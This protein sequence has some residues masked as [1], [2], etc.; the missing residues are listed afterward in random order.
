MQLILWQIISWIFKTIVIK[1]VVLTAL[2][3]VVS[4]LVPYAVSH[5]TSFTNVSSLN[6]AFSGIPDGLWWVLD[7][8]RLDYGLPLVISAFISR[9][10]IRRL[11]VI[12]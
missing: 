7:F 6:S 5:L 1:F 9:F 10:L 2:L 11:P 8:F 4:F 12:G 3:A